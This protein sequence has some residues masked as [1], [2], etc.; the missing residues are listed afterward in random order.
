MIE[1]NERGEN[2]PGHES[3]NFMNQRILLFSTNFRFTADV[4]DIQMRFSVNVTSSHSR[5]SSPNVTNFAQLQ[6]ITSLF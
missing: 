1:G 2:D 6:N 3:T 5:N 4:S